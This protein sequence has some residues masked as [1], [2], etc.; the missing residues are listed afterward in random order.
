MFE[1]FTE[2]CLR[3]AFSHKREM[4]IITVRVSDSV[5]PHKTELFP[6]GETDEE[7]SQD[8]TPLLRKRLEHVK[9]HW[10]TLSLSH[11]CMVLFVLWRI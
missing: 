11:A 5:P 3:L 10:P 8:I 1:L 9:S 2:A 7:V 6:G 4:V